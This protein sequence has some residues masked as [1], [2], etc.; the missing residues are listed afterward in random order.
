LH[1]QVTCGPHALYDRHRGGD[2]VEFCSVA[3]TRATFPWKYPV[4][5][6]CVIRF[7]ALLWWTPATFPYNIEA[8]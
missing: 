3:L 4:Q 6:I 2:G 7:V 8:Q 5:I 1:C